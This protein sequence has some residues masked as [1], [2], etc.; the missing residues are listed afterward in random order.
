MASFVRSGR[1]VLLG[2]ACLGAGIWLGRQSAGPAPWQVTPPPLPLAATAAA[3][4]FA[5]V[6]T[7]VLPGVVSVR[8]ELGGEPTLATLDN[9]R[10]R[11]D[12]SGS[13]FL[14]QQQGLV[15]TS[16]HVVVDAASV[17]V[18]VPDHGE[19]SAELVGDDAATDLALLRLVGAPS[20]LPSLRLGDGQLR[21]GDW[22]VAIGNPLGLSQTVTPGVVS[23]VGRHLHHRDFELTN[24][25]LQISAPLHPGSSGCPV[26]DLQG[27]VV[28]VTTQAPLEAQGISFAVPSHTL[29]WTLRAMQERPDGRVRRGYLGI[30]FAS[31]PGRGE[32]GGCASGV[33][34][35]RVLDGRPAHRAGLREGDVVVGFDGVPVADAGDLHQRIVESVPGRSVALALL[36]Q[37]QTL[38]VTAVL[39]EIGR[40]ES[41]PAN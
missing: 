18:D 5:D 3:P 33:Y 13:G 11:R 23:Y 38:P 26:V 20:D 30:E 21:P 27:R 4:S 7:A 8:V 16:R 24:D 36:R 6:V 31:V 1:I 10:P 41:D 14:V 40:S 25:F 17:Q 9:A 29:C 15:V 22:I 39:G 19:F 32:P 34:I 37:G 2:A 28:G 12:R 35:R